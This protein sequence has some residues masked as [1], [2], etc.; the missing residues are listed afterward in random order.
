MNEIYAPYCRD[1]STCEDINCL[2]GGEVLTL[3][4][5]L[6]F[7]HWCLA[8]EVLAS[9]HYSLVAAVGDFGAV[10]GFTL[11]SWQELEMLNLIPLSA[12]NYGNWLYSGTKN[13][14]WFKWH[15]LG[16]QEW[17]RHACCYNLLPSLIPPQVLHLIAIQRLAMLSKLTTSRLQA[18]ANWWC[19]W[20][21]ARCSKPSNVF[22]GS[23]SDTATQISPGH[24]VEA[25][26]VFMKWAFQI[27]MK[28]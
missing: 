18:V 24:A 10:K 4:T 26:S 7:W 21:E 28:K 19:E 25:N 27:I 22:H 9:S 23:H 13:V 14:D 2:G 17:A 8:S 15:A 5:S 6:H 11:I 3:G 20:K 12:N 1:K 16:C